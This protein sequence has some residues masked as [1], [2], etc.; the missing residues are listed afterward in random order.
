ML[1][2]E[3]RDSSLASATFAWLAAEDLRRRRAPLNARVAVSS[4]RQLHLFVEQ[5]RRRHL[6]RVP[7]ADD[8]QDCRDSVALEFAGRIDGIADAAR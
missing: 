6:R 8:A 1:R 5:C 2:A 3:Q 4:E 7:Q